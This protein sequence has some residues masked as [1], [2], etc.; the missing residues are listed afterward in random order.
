MDS[1]Y[2][3][4]SRVILPELKIGYI[5][6]S[7]IN[8]TCSVIS[9]PNPML[10]HLLESSWQDYSN[11]WLNI[12]FDEEIGILENK[13]RSLSGALWILGKTTLT[14]ELEKRL[15][16]VRHYTPPKQ[17]THLR[18]HFDRYPEI[19][20]R[21]YYSMGN[22]IVAM[23]IIEECQNRPVIMDRWYSL[24]IGLVT[25]LF[26]LSLLIRPRKYHYTCIYITSVTPFMKKWKN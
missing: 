23:E 20:R 25:M 21:A 16:A 13:K 26:E 8:S 15:G 17:I 6:L 3:N 7:L 5:N 24:H 22:Y 12:G 11:K 10:D 18:A 14:E 1:H 2:Y 19:V 4:L 9:S